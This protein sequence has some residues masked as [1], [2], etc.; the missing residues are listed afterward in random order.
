VRDKEFVF[1]K[2]NG[3]LKKV[4]ADDI[5]YLEAMGDYVKN[6]YSTKVSYCPFYV[7][8]DRRKI[9]SL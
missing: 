7:K 6:F 2:D 3:V 5:Q 4:S 1:I 9:A 8:I